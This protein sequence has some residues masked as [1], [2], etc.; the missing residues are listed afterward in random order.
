VLCDIDLAILGSPPQ[1]YLGYLREVREEYRH[2]ADDAF[3]KGRMRVVGHFLSLRR[4]YQTP[5][6]SA[7]LSSLARSNLADELAALESDPV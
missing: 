7:R 3:H 6:F 2:L 5:H 1:R 4:L